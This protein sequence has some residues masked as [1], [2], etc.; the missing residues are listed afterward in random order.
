MLKI[1]L[2]KTIRQIGAEPTWTMKEAAELTVHIAIRRRGM[3]VSVLIH[4]QGR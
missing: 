3:A 2:Q 1:E 4:K